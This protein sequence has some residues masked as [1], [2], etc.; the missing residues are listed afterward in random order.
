M[1]FQKENRNVFVALIIPSHI[2]GAK[3]YLTLNHAQREFKKWGFPG[4]KPFD[5]ELLIEAASRE[6]FEELGIEPIDLKLVSH[7][8]TRLNDGKDW[9]GY[10]FLCTAFTGIPR[11]LETTKHSEI[12]YMNLYDLI[13]VNADP[14]FRAVAELEVRTIQEIK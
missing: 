5:G 12:R 13:L 10:F 4:G 11:V 2:P 7:Y 8:T 1:E 14:E 9:L 6:A 3:T